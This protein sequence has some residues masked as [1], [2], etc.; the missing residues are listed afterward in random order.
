M[1]PLGRKIAMHDLA[2]L[3]HPVSKKMSTYLSETSQQTN[4]TIDYSALSAF[5]LNLHN[6]IDS[7]ISQIYLMGSRF[8][9]ICRNLECS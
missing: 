8:I 3:S 1:I 4:T 5:F 7:F 9:R 6:L 2:S